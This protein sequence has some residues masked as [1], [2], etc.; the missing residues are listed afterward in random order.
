MI[1]IVSMVAIDV[2]IGLDTPKLVIPH[3]FKVGIFIIP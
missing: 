2:A 1:A 3:K